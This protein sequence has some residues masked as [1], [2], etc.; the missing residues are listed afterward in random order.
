M[1]VFRLFQ[2]FNNAF[3]LQMFHFIKWIL[4]LPLVL[5]NVTCDKKSDPP[6]EPVET[7]EYIVNAYN[8]N[9]IYKCGEDC[10]KEQLNVFGLLEETEGFTSNQTK[11]EIK[12]ESLRHQQQIDI[13]V[14][15]NGELVLDFSESV[16]PDQT[17]Q[18]IESK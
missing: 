13:Q 17:I 14:F 15:R 10:F 7:I 8:Y 6:A 18:L 4:F 11:A 12:I 1:S 9:A 3:Y 5:I 2:Q 16:E